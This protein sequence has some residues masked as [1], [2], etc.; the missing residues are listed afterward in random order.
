MMN[1]PFKNRRDG[2]RQL[3]ELLMKF[4]GEKDLLILG[5]PRGGVPVAAEIAKALGQPFD[6]LVVRKLGVPGHEELAMGAI[7]SGGIRVL[8]DELISQLR[9]SQAQ[10]EAVNRRESGELAR[11][12]MLYRG[13]RASPAVAGRTVIVVDDGIATGSTMSAAI[14]LLRHQQAGRVIVAV[15]VAPSDTAERLRGEADEVVTV[16]EADDFVAV[17]RWYEDFSQTTDEDVRDLLGGGG[18]TSE[19]YPVGL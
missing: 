10:V 11:R 9:V 5:L 16:L 1:P 4:S 15:P 8:S 19:T 6:V 14:E 2:G 17:G 18:G 13:G 3:A 12:E 7:A